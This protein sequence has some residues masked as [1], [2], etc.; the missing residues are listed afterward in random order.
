MSAYNK[1]R[2][3]QSL[4]FIAYF[5]LVSLIL[6]LNGFLVR[7]APDVQVI[8]TY[9]V[10]LNLLNFILGGLGGGLLFAIFELFLLKN[11]FRKYGLV[12][13]TLGRAL[14]LA[15][16]YVILNVL[17]SFYYNISFTG[18]G[19]FHPE[20]LEGVSGF[21][22]GPEVILN[23]LFYGIFVLILTFFHQIIPLVGRGVLG[24][25]LFGRYRQPAVVYRTF[26]FIDMNSSTSVAE[27][28]GHVS[29]F[30]LMQ[31]FLVEAGAAIQDRKGEIYKYVGDEIIAHWT[32]DQGA[33][34][35]L[36]LESVLD[37]A[38]RL[39]S[40][41][42]YFQETYGVVP[43]FKAGLHVGEAMVGELGDWK[44]EVAYM[45][46]SLNTTARIQ[47]ACKSLK[48]RIL[49]SEDFQRLMIND[50]RFSMK[51]A[52]RG[53][54]RG[55]EAPLTLYRVECPSPSDGLIAEKESELADP[56][57]AMQPEPTSDATGSS[58]ASQ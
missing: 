14:F 36:A 41:A 24:K 19:P 55:R 4:A 18:H 12:I 26:L 11:L 22:T 37:F 49:V 51:K 28:I 52:A 9:D 29:F 38:H 48:A 16:T 40:R 17:L 20:V 50:S 30:Q 35:S 57:S 13:L 8:E 56:S 5:L 44:R 21:L 10:S 53:K 2:L 42:T 45:G 58:N 27:K 46:D 23:F 3:K 33:R 15:I 7:K 34:S 31:D 39:K 47:A 25:F 1:L 32:I 6:F 43:D 54:L